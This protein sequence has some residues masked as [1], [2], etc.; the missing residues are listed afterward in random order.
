MPHSSLLLGGGG[1]RRKNRSS[2]LLFHTEP[3]QESRVLVGMVQN[4]LEKYS[5]NIRN[6]SKL[7][8]SETPFRHSKSRRIET[9]KTSKKFF[10]NVNYSFINELKSTKNIYI[11]MP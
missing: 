6:V 5:C 8:V 10:G 1:R 11:Y 7:K 3:E 9:R 4:H 2:R